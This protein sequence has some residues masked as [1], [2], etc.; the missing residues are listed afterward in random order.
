MTSN[1]NPA[2]VTLM[3]LI[4]AHLVQISLARNTY[5]YVLADVKR[6][7]MSAAAKRLFE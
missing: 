7:A 4:C 3:S 2:L 5:A 6:A 1:A